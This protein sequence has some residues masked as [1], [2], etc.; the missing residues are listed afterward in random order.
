MAIPTRHHTDLR[1]PAPRAPLLQRIFATPEEVG[2][3]PHAWLLFL[4]F[5]IM[6]MLTMSPRQTRFWLCVAAIVIFVPTY[7]A[8]FRRTGRAMYPQ[9]GIIA[10]LGMLFTP[11]NFGANVFFH[12]AS[13]MCGQAMAPRRA[14]LA[15]GFLC[16]WML[17]ASFALDLPDYYFLPGIIVAIVLVGISIAERQQELANSALKRSREEVERLAQMAERERIAR[18][19]HDVLGHTLSVITL[20]AELAGKLIEAEPAKARAEL[21][22]IAVTS[23]K[24]LASVRETVGNYR[25]VGLRDEL[26]SAQNALARADVAFEAHV[27]NVALSPRHE[28]LLALIVREAV[29]NVIR[30]AHASHCRLSLRT[31]NNVIE[32]V[33]ED[34]GQGFDGGEGQGMTGMRERLAVLGGTLAVSGMAGTRLTIRVPESLTS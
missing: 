32:L 19:L 7:Y 33:I 26:S 10:L 18:D 11:I 23:R 2:F 8:S 21:S 24:A 6:P 34:D 16:A 14:L 25:R 31:A 3:L 27:D 17:A 22:E 20:K 5:F 4:A 15:V 9:I 30:H 29:T 28:T 13:F 12:Y 1:D